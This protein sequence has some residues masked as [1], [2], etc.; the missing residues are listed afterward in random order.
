MSSYNLSCQSDFPVAGLQK[1]EDYLTPVRILSTFCT[2]SVASAWFTKRKVKR[3][4]LFFAHWLS[5]LL[6]GLCFCVEDMM[7]SVCWA[8]SDVEGFVKTLKFVE[9]AASNMLAI[10]NLAICV[11]LALIIM[12][13]RTLSR[14]KSVSSPTLISVFLFVSLGVAAATVPFWE[15]AVVLRTAFWFANSDEGKYTFIYASLFHVEFIVGVCMFVMVVWLL[16]FRI[17]EIKECWTTY[18]RIR[19]YFGL[20]LL[21]MV[22][23][24]ALGICGTIFVSLNN[25]DSR[26]LIWSW[27]L[28]YIHIALD[29]VVLYGVLRERHMDERACCPHSS[30]LPNSMSAGHALSTG[31]AVR[32]SR[33]NYNGVCRG[34]SREVGTVAPPV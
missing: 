5:G 11:N 13:H 4:S 7:L 18:V 14:V 1:G 23:N 2:A 19:Y 29:T 17:K 21:G 33:S 9:L 15:T 22:V 8:G 34:S 30:N 25:P 28:R 12:S 3:L 32:G 27:I 24:L 26:I 20:T 16:L 31:A 6:I 10:T